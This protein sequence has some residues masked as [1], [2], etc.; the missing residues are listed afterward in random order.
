MSNKFV[1]WINQ[2]YND[3]LNKFQQFQIDFSHRQH[4]WYTNYELCSSHAIIYTIPYVWNY[5]KPISNRKRFSISLM[6]NSKIF[7][8]VTD[9][10][11]F[12][13]LID[14]KYEYYSKTS[15]SEHLP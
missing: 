7:D 14:D 11:L 4:Q 3:I 10:H 6:N 15:I 9:L 13:E 8:N 5:Y 1:V 2:N 12:I